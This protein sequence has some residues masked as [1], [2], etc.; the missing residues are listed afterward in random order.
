[1]FDIPYLSLVIWTPI[2]GVLVATSGI[3]LL[4]EAGVLPGEPVAWTLTYA[5]DPVILAWALT[6]MRGGTVNG[7]A[8]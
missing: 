4:A 7:H 5:F 8:Q 3:D 6:R 1:M 2:V